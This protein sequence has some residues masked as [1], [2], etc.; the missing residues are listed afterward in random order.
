MPYDEALATRVRDALRNVDGVEE[1]RMFGGLAFLVN[2]HMC[3]GV[4]GRRLV[5]RLGD[6]G[7]REALTREHTAPMDFTG[8][9]SKNMVY[10]DPPG[11]ADEETLKAWIE[12]ALAFV[13]GLPRK[14]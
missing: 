13:R 8:R 10:V 2:G 7:T 1:R 14:G 11:F 5:L 12:R 9:V 4:L 3:C 6:A